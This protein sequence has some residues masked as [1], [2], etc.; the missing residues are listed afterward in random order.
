MPQ[1]SGFLGPP[2]GTPVVPSSPTPSTAEPELAIAFVVV[3]APATLNAVQLRARE[4]APSVLPSRHRSLSHAHAFLCGTKTK[5]ALS[6]LE[7]RENFTVMRNLE[8]CLPPRPLARPQRA[9][10][11]ERVVLS[12]AAR[13]VRHSD[14]VALTVTNPV[15][16]QPTI[17]AL[18][19]PK[20]PLPDLTRATL[21][22]HVQQYTYIYMYTCIYTCRD[23]RGRPG[24]LALT[25]PLTS[26]CHPIPQSAPPT[27]TYTY[28][29]R[30]HTTHIYMMTE[31]LV[32]VQKDAGK[33]S[34]NRAEGTF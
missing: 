6:K 7:P 16:A 24:L 14:V 2:P 34:S 4:Y 28:L 10:T 18:T 13:S 15:S 26:R 29:Y 27:V 3:V 22:T 17:R 19:S 23:L 32:L 21:R 12:A 9:S 20:R 1:V 11:R 5:V 25:R 8:R 33:H 30:T 31:T